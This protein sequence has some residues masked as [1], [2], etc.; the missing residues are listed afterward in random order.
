[1]RNIVINN[2]SSRHVDE[3]MLTVAFEISVWDPDVRTVIVFYD[4]LIIIKSIRPKVAIQIS[5]YNAVNTVRKYTAMGA[6]I[7][8]VV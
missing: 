7:V 4:M 8:S 1:M 5:P 2:C 6:G 3:D